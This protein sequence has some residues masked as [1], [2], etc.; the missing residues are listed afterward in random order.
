M[1]SG[2]TVRVARFLDGQK[3]WKTCTEIAQALG[4]SFY[5]VSPAIGWLSRANFCQYRV[6]DNGQA[7][8]EMSDGRTA[9]DLEALRNDAFLARRD[10]I[11]AKRQA[12]KKERDAHGQ[13]QVNSYTR[14]AKETIQKLKKRITELEARIKRMQR[15]R[16]Q[17]ETNPFGVYATDLVDLRRKLQGRPSRHVNL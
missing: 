8:W 12:A 1:K 13:S 16:E 6:M 9:A 5:S 15:E 11:D 7:G 4:A 17:V 14:D 3:E 2:M 10:R